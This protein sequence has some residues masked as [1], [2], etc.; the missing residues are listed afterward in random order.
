[1]LPLRSLNELSFLPRLILGGGVL[2]LPLFFSG[3][4]F[5]ESLRRAGETSRPLASNLGGA[6][7]GGLLE[8]GSLV[9]G[10]KSLYLMALALYLAAWL[11]LRFRGRS[12]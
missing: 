2:S 10:I 3:L 12:G 8:Y 7:V 4:V 5:G 1:V 9:W 11:A 6:M